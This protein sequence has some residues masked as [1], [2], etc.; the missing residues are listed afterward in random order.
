[1]RGVASTIVILC[2]LALSACGDR[3]RPPQ[4]PPRA[5]SDATPGAA[6]GASSSASSDA[7][8]PGAHGLVRRAALF[9]DPTR[10]RGRLSPDGAYVSWLAPM[11]GALNV[12]TAPADAPDEAR[13]VTESP[14]PGLVQ[15]EWARNSTHILYVELTPDGDG[16]RV[17][18]VDVA[19]G[20]RR[21][22]TPG[23]ADTHAR[24]VDMS[25]DYPSDVV[26]AANDRDRE[27]Y[28]LHRVNLATGA[29]RRVL[30]ND[31]GF[32][33]FLLNDAL[34]PVLAERIEDD[35]AL[36]VYR[37]AARGE[38]WSRFLVF[39][40]EDAWQSGV[41]ALDGAGRSVYAR[42]S[43]GAN[44]AALVRIDLE[45]GARTFLA[46]VDGADVEETLFHPVT[47]EADAVSVNRLYQEWL[48]LTA[49]GARAM[50]YLED[51]LS[52]EVHVLSRTVDDGRWIVY[53]SDA[54]NPGSYYTF[55]REAGEAGAPDAL[56]RFLDIRPELMGGAD[57][58]TAPVVI[59]A[60]DGLDLVAYLSVP[61]HADANADG[62]PD[63][64]LPMVISVIE[65]PGDRARGGYN[66]VDHWLVDRGFASLRLNVRGAWGFGKAYLNAGDGEWGGAIQDDLLDAAQWAVAREVADP[67][68]VGV[69]GAG[70]GGLTAMTAVARDPDSFA[71][72]AA[73]NAPMD[74]VAFLEN[75]PAPWRPYLPAFS[76]VLGD[77]DDPAQRE[78]LAARSPVSFAS[79]IARPTL[80]IQ[81]GADPL[82]QADLARE[83]AE[84]VSR[85]PATLL[86]FETAG[87]KIADRRVRTAV[88][89]AAEAFLGSCLGVDAEPLGDELAETSVAASV[90]VEHV[91][92]LAA[93]LARH[94]ADNR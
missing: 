69:M 30:V 68:R 85:A 52:G 81:G 24:V 55:D 66:A 89:A 63:A 32:T 83:A 72:A 39:P 48:P 57:V 77:P 75:A 91:P 82:N 44:A 51:H 42:D 12:W 38:D 79:E 13:P 26:I 22:L 61:A 28:D 40:P 54:N 27:R 25:W 88:F 1:M 35:G 17:W 7:A 70:L 59:P 2:A 80:I 49:R 93:A 50:R 31:R 94:V 43:R 5:Q 92:G 64:P 11:G 60:R 20:A 37:A 62:R 3:A 19:T 71:C 29:S 16:G 21:D 10:I 36:A 41:I 58:Q 15:Y 67:A 6:T 65:G 14:P 33:R 84:R 56:S 34:E 9:D 73:I 8:A 4:T 90:G 23:D 74:L 86:V 18:A 47:G 87:V 45:T 53:V 78:A 76:R 46:G